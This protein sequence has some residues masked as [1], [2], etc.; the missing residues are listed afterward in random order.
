MKTSQN[1]VGAAA[2]KPADVHRSHP[3]AYGLHTT[4][5]TEQILLFTEL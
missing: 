2:I 1:R 5:F 4:R 3:V